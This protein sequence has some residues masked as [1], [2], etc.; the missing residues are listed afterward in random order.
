VVNSTGVVQGAM[1]TLPFGEDFAESGTQE[2]HR[3]TTYDRDSG[4][5]LDYA[6]NRTYAPVTSRFSRVDP[7]AARPSSPQSWNRY[8][9][10]AG[11]PVNSGDPTGLT[12]VCFWTL[13][14]TRNMGG[15]RSVNYWT[16]DC[17]DL[18]DR[19]ALNDW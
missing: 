13:V 15:D 2:K 11:D 6:L 5:G 7:E 9:Y 4:T 12:T 8:A 16:V 10:V 1:G 14:G 18:G 17:I 3:F 19:T